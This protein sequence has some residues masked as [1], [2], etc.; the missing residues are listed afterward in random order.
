MLEVGQA[1][2]WSS[3]AY[4]MA[5]VAGLT[6][7]ALVIFGMVA[8]KVVSRARNEDLVKVLEVTGLA[9]S[10]LLRKRATKPRTKRGER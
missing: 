9:L 10:N 3:I 5:L 7:L 4:G 8:W 2:G 1:E 6:A